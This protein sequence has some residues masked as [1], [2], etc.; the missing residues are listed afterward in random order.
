MRRSAALRLLCCTAA[1][2]LM[3]CAGSLTTQRQNGT[4]QPVVIGSQADQVYTTG[5]AAQCLLP[6][7]RRLPL[8]ARGVVEVIRFHRAFEL[9]LHLIG[10]CRIAEPPAPAVA[11]PD[12]DTQLSGDAPGRAGETQQKGGEDPVRQWSRAPVQQGLGEV[13]EGALAAMTPVAFAPGSILVCAPLANVVALAART[14]QRAIV[15]PEPMDVHLALFGAEEV[16]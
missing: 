8:V 3:G 14:L 6:A 10:Q 13:V 4:T 1:L 15:P 9:A 16:V 7:L 2:A 5:A 12:M 11:G